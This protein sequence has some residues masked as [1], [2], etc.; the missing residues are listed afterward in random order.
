MH[1][2]ASGKTSINFGEPAGTI[3]PSGALTHMGRLSPAVLKV[4]G[5]LQYLVFKKT[6]QTLRLERQGSKQ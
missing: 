3:V 5:S 6:S 4:E 2:P 1:Q